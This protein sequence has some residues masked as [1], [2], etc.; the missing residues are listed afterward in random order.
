MFAAIL[1]VFLDTQAG[2]SYY[3]SHMGGSTSTGEGDGEPRLGS[4]DCPPGE[5][6]KEGWGRAG[7]GTS[8]G[9]SPKYRGPCLKGTAAWPAGDHVGCGHAST[10]VD[11]GS[12]FIFG[13]HLGLPCYIWRYWCPLGLYLHGEV[14]KSLLKKRPYIPFQSTL[15]E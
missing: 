8:L 2:Y 9:M 6:W 7:L 12:P 3:S 14:I 15:E 1:P 4:K 5:D 13:I 10:A 11:L